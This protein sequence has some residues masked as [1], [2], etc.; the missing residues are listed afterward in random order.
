MSLATF[1]EQS[2]LM[3]LV[4]FVGKSLRAIHDGIYIYIHILYTHVYI[5]T[6]HDY[7]SPILLGKNNVQTKAIEF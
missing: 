5:Y 4:L 1:K 6:Y 2:G 7:E 3:V